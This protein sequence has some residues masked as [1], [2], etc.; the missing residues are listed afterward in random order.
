[1]QQT[2]SFE[3][4]KRWGISAW[5]IIGIILL[6]VIAAFA[7]LSIRAVLIPFLIALV[8]VYIIRPMAYYL[9]KKGVPRTLSIIISYLV[10]ILVVALLGAYVGPILYN[11]GNGLIK[12][13]PKYVATASV[14]ATD[15][16]NQHP[17]FKGSQAADIVDGLWKS[18][19]NFLQQAVEDIPSIISTVS[20]SLINFILG[21]I[22]A[23]YILKDS[24][25]IKTTLREMIPKKHRAEGMH[26]VQKID[27]IVGGFLKG[28]ALVALSVGI[29]SSIA[30]SVLGVEYAI[31]LGLLIGAFNIIPY[32]GP[33]IGGFPAVIIALGT[34]W[35]LAL[36]VVVV[37]LVVQQFDSIFIS[38]RIMSSQV[39]LHPTVVIFAILAGESFMGIPGM[40]IAIPLAA[41]GKALYLHFRERNV[42]DPDQQ[43]SCEIRQPASV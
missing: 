39:N 34:S 10:I 37:L 29:L 9:D 7:I 4:V 30:L 15:F 35:Q 38:P 17:V 2:D 19:S 8:F 25:V 27:C 43:G 42:I 28:Q 32:L 1:M 5:S 16:I 21:P 24:D 14:F 11:E 18:I 23:F 3:R 13:M 12:N 41:V 40:L 22:I 6:L 33:V 26:I 36:A 31:L 20:T